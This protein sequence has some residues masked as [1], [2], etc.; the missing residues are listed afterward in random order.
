MSLS[1]DPNADILKELT[2]EI[3]KLHSQ[4]DSNLSS[5]YQGSGE[6]PNRIYDLILK[7]FS[8]I[9]LMI[10]PF[11]HLFNAFLFLKKNNLFFF[12]AQNATNNQQKTQNARRTRVT[13]VNSSKLQNPNGYSGTDLSKPR[14]WTV[15]KR[16]DKPKGN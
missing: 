15:I 5:Q 8:S 6:Y 3:D 9:S 1:Y 16:V 13:S 11:F 7:C 4:A 12:E 14:H 2:A 10:C